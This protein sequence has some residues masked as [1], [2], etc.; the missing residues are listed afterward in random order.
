MAL[1]IFGNPDDGTDIFFVDQDGNKSPS[2]LKSYGWATRSE[3]FPTF[4]PESIDIIAVGTQGVSAGA[5]ADPLRDLGAMLRKS[6]PTIASSSGI[7]SNLLVMSLGAGGQIARREFKYAM[8]AKCR[9]G[10]PNPTAI[11][12]WLSDYDFRSSSN[13]EVRDT[14]TRRV[15]DCSGKSC[16]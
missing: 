14:F 2:P 9:K 3:S 16:D 10:D 6:S 11:E 12:I 1:P 8:V 4:C 13:S 5:A 7:S 15:S